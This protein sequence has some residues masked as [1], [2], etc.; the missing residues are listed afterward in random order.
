MNWLDSNI[1]SLQM[2]Q[3]A[4]TTLRNLSLTTDILLEPLN[5]PHEALTAVH[6]L[7]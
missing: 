7:D 3:I 6:K 1:G 5:L 4:I 2:R